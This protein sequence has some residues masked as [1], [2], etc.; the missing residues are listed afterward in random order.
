MDIYYGKSVVDTTITKINACIKF[1]EI[2][3][4]HYSLGE[5]CLNCFEILKTISTIYKIIKIKYNL[6]YTIYKYNILI[7]L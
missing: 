2:R 3:L 4:S 5:K 7:K 6:N 1:N